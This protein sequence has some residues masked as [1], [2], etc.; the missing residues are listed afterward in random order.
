MKIHGMPKA[1]RIVLCGAVCMALTI[2]MERTNVCA[3]E[4]TKDSQV[5]S[6]QIS[7]AIIENGTLIIGTHLIHIDGLT[8]ELYEIAMES[9][10]EYDQT[11]LYYKSELANGRWYEITNAVSIADISTSGTVV[12]TAEIEEMGFTHMTDQ[13]GITRDLRIARIVNLFDIRPVYDLEAMKELEPV[14]LQYQ[15]LREKDTKTPSDKTYQ[16]MLYCFFEELP[17]T[18]ALS[19]DTTNACDRELAGLQSYKEDLIARKKSDSWVEITDR[20]MGQVDAQ[21]RCES[22]NLLLGQ[23]EILLQYT[24]GEAHDHSALLDERVL[25]EITEDNPAGFIVNA[26]VT[27]AV[28]QSIANVQEGL[29]KYGAKRLTQGTTVASQKVYQYSNDL[30]STADAGDRTGSDTATQRLLNI[31]N[32]LS[33]KMVNQEGERS[34]LESEL[35]AAALENY[36]E[37]LR[38][39]VNAQY[40]KAA[41]E[42]ASLASRAG[43]LTQQKA[44]T[45]AARQEYQTLLEG[46]MKRMPSAQAKE[47]VSQRIDYV[48]KLRAAVPDDDVRTYHLETVESHLKWLQKMLA[49]VMEADNDTSESQALKQALDDLE[50]QRQSALDGND[51]A[52]ERRLAAEMEAVQNDLDSM[53]ADFLAVLS[54]DNASESDKAK[55][56]ANLSDK[57]TAKALSDLAD[58]VCAQLRESTGGI[59]NVGEN[60]GVGEG[61]GTEQDKNT[62]SAGMDN[63]A[64]VRSMEN[65]LDAFSTLAQLEPDAAGQALDEINDAL[66]NASGITQARKEELNGKLGD[67]SREIHDAV[68]KQNS[69]QSTDEL[70]TLIEEQLASMSGGACDKNKAGILIALSM[71]AQ[72]SGSRNA[73]L[74]AASLANQYASEQNEYLFPKYDRHAQEYVSL[75]AVSAVL[76][77]RY[78]FDDAESSITLS[79]A[80]TYHVF[81][82]CYISPKES[83]ECFDVSARYIASCSWAA[84]KTADMIPEIERVYQLL[85][86]GA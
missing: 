61:A 15:K 82:T 45:D 42:G 19:N 52:K 71:Y 10:G 70:L 6:V 57:S 27:E 8:D 79:K 81:D 41:A 84:L 72:E 13:Y 39:G 78:I 56:L 4:S 73:K 30:I 29:A 37:K 83:K 77:Y 63:E 46:L 28:G 86:G 18:A 75:K 64:A 48:P 76:Q 40:Q 74:L 43:I 7:D 17:K 34:L 5:R 55:A 36:M 65:T 51:L 23:L 62:G 47:Y 50:K 32:I 22:L 59:G 3:V 80:K 1:L 24:Y 21:R 66:E 85:M 16:E 49:Q 58:T 2:N 20:V 44:D 53:N 67:I 25:F 33:D 12:D 54:S 31:D 68:K 9:A 38:G 11:K 69:P 60:G 14:R 26:D 35:A